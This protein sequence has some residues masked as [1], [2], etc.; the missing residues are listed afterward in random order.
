[1]CP[2]PRSQTD[3]FRVFGAWGLNEAATGESTL[4]PQAQSKVCRNKSVRFDFPFNLVE[5]FH[6]LRGRSRYRGVALGLVIN[7]STAVEP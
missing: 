7:S 4:E 2:S 5:K 6:A 1:M 3:F